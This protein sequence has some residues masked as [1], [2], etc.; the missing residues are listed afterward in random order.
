MFYNR[1]TEAG[2]SDFFGVALVHAIESFKYA[3]MIFCRDSYTVIFDSNLYLFAQITQMNAYCT[4]LFIIFDSII[5]EIINDFIQ[6]RT[7]AVQHR[8]IPVNIKMNVFL[9]S[10]LFQSAAHISDNLTHIQIFPVIRS[11]SLIK[12]RYPNRIFDQRDQALGFIINSA[13]KFLYIFLSDHTISDDLCKTGYCS[14][15]RHQLM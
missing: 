3:L 14:Q 11:F 7:H 10:N 9:I 13:C 2:T 12:L 1:K 4:V 6:N 5:A 15:R 8:F